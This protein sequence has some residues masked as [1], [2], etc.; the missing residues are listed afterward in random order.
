MPPMSPVP[1]ETLPGVPLQ[2]TDW[3]AGSGAA[4]TY[5][6][7][8]GGLFGGPPMVTP[9]N[10]PLGAPRATPPAPTA[11]RPALP[12]WTGLPDPVQPR[13][14]S[15]NDPLDAPYTP[16][17][18]V[19]R[20]AFGA[21]AAPPPAPNAAAGAQLPG[22]R[23]PLTPTT[24]QNPYAGSVTSPNGGAFTPQQ[25]NQFGTWLNQQETAGGLKPTGVQNGRM[26]YQLPPELGGGAYAWDGEG[27][28]PQNHNALADRLMRQRA[29]E[30]GHVDAGAG[31][32]HAV[33]PTES[34]AEF[35]LPGAG[36]QTLAR[37]GLSKLKSF[38][39][40]PKTAVPAAGEAAAVAR[41]VPKIPSAI[42]NVSVLRP[43]LGQNVAEIASGVG[44]VTNPLRALYQ[45]G[46]APVAA[47]TSGRAA[48]AEALGAA[49]TAASRLL[50]S[51]TAVGAANSFGAGARNEDATA[52]A[53]RM[54]DPTA[55]LR[56]P[57][58]GFADIVT[59]NSM[60]EAVPPALE[61]LL[62][63]ATLA[64]GSARNAL[65]IT[66][67]AP[68]FGSYLSQ[69]NR[70]IGQTLGSTAQNAE[71]EAGN[72]ARGLRNTRD[73]INTGNGDP[74]NQFDRV[75]QL[76][77]DYRKLHEEYYATPGYATSNEA[78]EKFRAGAQRIKDEMAKVNRPANY[79]RAESALNLT[80]ARDRLLAE[81]P[82][83]VMRQRITE[84]YDQQMGAQMPLTPQQWSRENT[85]AIQVP[86]P[87][88]DDIDQ[89][90]RRQGLV[91]PSNPNAPV[92]KP[93][94]EGQAV[95]DRQLDAQT[96]ALRVPATGMYQTRDLEPTAKGL[97]DFVT[98]V[99]EAEGAE[100]QAPTN[101]TA[102]PAPAPGINP[103]DVVGRFTDGN[104][105]TP[106]TDVPD[107]VA[108]QL[109]GRPLAGNA[110]VQAPTAPAPGV[111]PTDPVGRFTEGGFTTPGS[112]VPG[113]VAPQLGGAPLASPTAEPPP[114][115]A[116]PEEVRN[117]LTGMIGGAGSIGGALA[118]VDKA[119]PPMGFKQ[120]WEGLDS[121]S[122]FLAIGGLSL[123]AITTLKRMFASEDDDD[124][125]FLEKVLPLLGIGA[126]AF[127]AGGGT[128]WGDK[129]VSMPTMQNY[130]N[131][132]EAAKTNVMP[133]FGK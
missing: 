68:N 53:E 63:P 55:R 115:Q 101:V 11:P 32:V 5:K 103:T 33:K 31:A 91:S 84:Q 56:D 76:S 10:T 127:G 93:L 111:N 20:E 70:D 22:V 65:G 79:G 116:K 128:L 120:Y 27:A 28:G 81:T 114:P 110:A 74:N 36:V 43:G 117:A 113:S 34:P 90:Y 24:P 7:P 124:E 132:Y 80:R 102:P 38:V 126:A 87:T 75:R 3:G 8:T 118:G 89:S 2:P 67:D 47:L 26:T 46:R 30:L 95:F 48:G 133:M 78:A 73:Q 25:Q 108:P 41:G 13:I 100:A 6:P 57:K 14:R 129:G 61:R 59:A 1:G 19:S 40:S 45:L 98:S 123:A 125:G 66:R 52:Y 4:T 62:L 23:G 109:S 29:Q 51:F 96:S 37:G 85:A 105:A 130:T 88:A 39:S 64:Y 54:K 86:F 92:K 15:S 42:P 71:Y 12:N 119:P 44:A 35:F 94:R 50:P 104:V 106:G 69:Q 112:Q 49:G 99:G 82:D 83:P 58:T 97:G 18:P 107:S 16:P 131:L 17:N 121:S 60:A 77:D 122:K 9:G 21:A 72:L